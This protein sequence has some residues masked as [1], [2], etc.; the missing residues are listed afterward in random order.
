MT[1]MISR[2]KFLG[3][4][5]A[6]SLLFSLRNTPVYGFFHQPENKISDFCRR[7]IPIGRILETE[8]YYVWGA[9]PVK[10]PDGEIHVFYSRWNADQGMGGWLNASEIA[11]A[12]ADSPESPFEY[13]ETVLAP[14]GEGYWDGTTCHNPHIKEVDGKYCLFYIGNSNRKR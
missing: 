6:S 10:A 11:H 13:I 3:C 1:D 7:L 14:R 5:A 4:S 12:V 2:R 9:S 8:G